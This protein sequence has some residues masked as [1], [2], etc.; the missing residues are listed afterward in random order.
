MAEPVS[1][2]IITSAREEE[3]EAL[4]APAAPPSAWAR[5]KKRISWFFRI[6]ESQFWVIHGFFLLVC[7]LFVLLF[8][9]FL[10]GAA[11]DK[12]KDRRHPAVT[13]GEERA[14]GNVNFPRVVM[15]SEYWTDPG[16]DEAW[17]NG[18]SATYFEDWEY[19]ARPPGE[20]TEIR[21]INAAQYGSV[22]GVCLLL[23]PRREPIA[24]VHDWVLL[25]LHFRPDYDEF[26]VEWANGTRRLGAN[27]SDDAATRR[28]AAS[29]AAARNASAAAG[30]CARYRDEPIA[31]EF[32]SRLVLDGANSRSLGGGMRVPYNK[33]TV[34]YYEY[35]KK[36]TLGGGVSETVSFRQHSS[37][38][39]FLNNPYG[40]PL[41][42]GD[43]DA[44]LNQR[45]AL[46][47]ARVWF[48]IP[49]DSVAVA[50]EVRG[51]NP[52]APF[53]VFTTLFALL[54]TTRS[55]FELFV[56]H[57][58]P[59][60]RRFL[61]RLHDTEVAL[62]KEVGQMDVVKRAVEAEHEA[63]RRLSTLVSHH[64]DR[65]GPHDHEGL[66]TLVSH[67]RD[68]EGPHDHEGLHDD[69]SDDDSDHDRHRA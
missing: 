9:Q 6:D 21:F 12:R 3:K 62:E 38:L 43:G 50:S 27:A 5:T 56:H 61:P 18:T 19:G 22:S 41:A 45:G 29:A 17:F 67:H 25:D 65:E 37:D 66:S 26:C 14:V 64:R 2:I 10:A 20:P 51:A 42:L 59:L 58:P 28:G 52:L 63:C 15:C 11:R 31:Q 55:I 44:A 23:R 8:L 53:V 39:Y 32:T 13:L 30:E 24:S 34:V 60:R 69:D 7:V 33:E 47:R 68:C 36:E 35:V 48:N 16:L 1:E 46:Y 49:F 40:L 4:R 57:A 54:S